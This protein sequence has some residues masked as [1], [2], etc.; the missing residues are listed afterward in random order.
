METFRFF[1][2]S[3]LHFYREYTSFAAFFA[4]SVTSQL[5]S[6]T[7]KILLSKHNFH[8]A[9]TFAR[10]IGGYKNI[11]CILITGDMATTGRDEDLQIAYEFIN[12][13]KRITKLG[14][15]SWRSL[16]GLPTLAGCSNK[17][18][19]IL[20][21]NHDRYVGPQLFAGGIK[22]DQVFRK[23]WP[24]KA[25]SSHQNTS[26]RI[27]PRLIRHP[28]G[29]ERIAFIAVDLTLKTS[30]HESCVLGSLG[31]GCAYKH[32]IDALER[33]TESVKKDFNTNAIMWMVHFAPKFKGISAQ[34]IL[35]DDDSL[36][37]RAKRLK[38]KHIFCG[39]T[40]ETDSYSV[41]GVCIHCAGSA[42]AEPR[43]PSIKEIN[44]NVIH[45]YQIKVDSG[46]IIDF[47]K[48]NLYYIKGAIKREREL[49]ALGCTN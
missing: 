47:E 28:N 14:T 13:P 37:A 29:K 24:P 43:W 1:H 49:P 10:I 46:K 20:P 3:D 22:F 7:R 4:S 16:S 11:D 42:T 6:F 33:I 34:T 30:L 17:N 27:I 36:I 5:T 32:R 26:R 41:D 48:E 23:Y 35:I 25:G 19:I 39:H 9:D 21:G 8:K 18:I 15:F 44:K 12:D 45:Y 31:Q 2:L 40:H 38:I